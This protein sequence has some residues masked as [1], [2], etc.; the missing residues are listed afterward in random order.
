MYPKAAVNVIDRRIDP[1]PS[2]LEQGELGRR[3]QVT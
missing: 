3:T 1:R 2:T